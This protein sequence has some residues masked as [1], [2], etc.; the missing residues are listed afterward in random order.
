[1]RFCTNARSVF[2]SKYGYCVLKAIDSEC[3]HLKHTTKKHSQFANK[4][5]F[6]SNTFCKDR[7]DGFYRHPLN[8]LGII[9]VIFDSL[10]HTSAL[11]FLKN[12]FFLWLI[13]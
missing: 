10:K 13:L 3:H 8:C 1:M 2:S 7:I 5:F 4:N 6:N 9:Q 11:C 12:K